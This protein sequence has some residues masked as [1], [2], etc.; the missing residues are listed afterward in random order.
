VKWLLPREKGS[1]N[2]S[3]DLQSFSTAANG[4]NEYCINRQS[5][6]E[7]PAE[8]PESAKRMN[9]IQHFLLN[10][11]ECVR[12]ILFRFWNKSVSDGWHTPCRVTFQVRVLYPSRRSERVERFGLTS[13]ANPFAPDAAPSI[14]IRSPPL[15]RLPSH[16]DRSCSTPN[17]R[18]LPDG[19]VRTAITQDIVSNCPPSRFARRVGH[20]QCSRKRW[21]TRQVRMKT[22]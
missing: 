12:G 17:P 21:P 9:S 5:R 7:I 14:L 10:F 2:A 11:D 19:G 20:P 16:N 18:V 22:A 4:G 3:D 15:P 6:Y 1:G 13:A 8:P